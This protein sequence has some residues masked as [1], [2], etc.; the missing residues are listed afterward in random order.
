[1]SS[2]L[3]LS[4]GDL[5]V[6]FGKILKVIKIN[7]NTATFK[8]FFDFKGNNGLTY[9]LNLKNLDD[10][11]IRLLVS[12]GKIQSLLK[13]IINKSTPGTDSPIFDAKTALCQN[14]FEET[15]WVIKNL[16]LEKKEKLNTLSSGKL[17]IFKRAMTQ[18]T[19]EIAASTNIS[20]EKAEALII[21]GLK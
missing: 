14:K 4:N 3:K 13:Q 12:K 20:P 21:S 18:A 6:R 7:Q 9:S 19:Q 16:W 1:M 2:K 15:L 10:G 17:S 11:H 8:P 5:V